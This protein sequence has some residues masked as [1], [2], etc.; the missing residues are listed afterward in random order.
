[1]AGWN[2]QTL[3]INIANRSH[4]KISA[5]YWNALWNLIIKTI[6]NNAEGIDMLSKLILNDLGGMTADE[7]EAYIKSVIKSLNI[8][9]D[10]EAISSAIDE[11]LKAHPISVDAR[12]FN[13]EP[14]TLQVGVDIQAGQELEFYYVT[15]D[16]YEASATGPTAFIDLSIPGLMSSKKYTL[17]SIVIEEDYDT[18]TFSGIYSGLTLAMIVLLNNHTDDSTKHITAVDRETWNNKVDKNTLNNS[19]KQLS[20]AIDASAFKKY[21]GAD[22]ITIEEDTPA[23]WAALGTGIVRISSLGLLNG[24]PRDYGVLENIPLDYDGTEV[25]QRFVATSATEDINGEEFYRVGANTNWYFGWR[26]TIGY[27]TDGSTITAGDVPFGLHALTVGCS[28]ELSLSTAAGKVTCGRVY[29]NVNAVTSGVLEASDGGIKVLRKG[30]YL[31][32]ASVYCSNM[33]AGNAVC[34]AI[35]Q[36]TS[37]TAGAFAQTAG[38]TYTTVSL[39][40]RVLS[41]AA[42][43]IFYLYAYNINSATGIIEASNNTL[44]T[45][46]AI[47]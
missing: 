40:P 12:D 27:G 46:I 23:N 42:G 45:V 4:Q 28:S 25:M 21:L 17:T 9:L 30:R 35:Y 38:R 33:T 31:V 34:A 24:Q 2:K 10:D 14:I 47:D 22:P 3:D 36:G 19:L 1:M 39:P 7:I 13:G 16:G 29:S 43:E 8:E 18:Y 37:A 5:E 26:K 32:S 20:E 15:Q 41:L 44:L 11:Y 6:N